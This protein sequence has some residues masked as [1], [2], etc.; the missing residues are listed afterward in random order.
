M[1]HLPVAT[2]PCA[3]CP[4]TWKTSDAIYGPAGQSLLSDNA[5]ILISQRPLVAG[6]YTVRITQPGQPDLSWSFR[7][8]APVRTVRVSAGTVKARYGIGRRFRVFSSLSTGDIMTGTYLA[9][10]GMRVTL[11]KRWGNGHWRRWKRVT[12]PELQDQAVTRFTPRRT[13]ILRLRAKFHGAPGYS[14]SKSE[15]IKLTIHR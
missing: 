11:Q 6:T 12:M 9:L 1:A 15:V 5:V 13:G 10:Y 7:N 4:A 3:W 14:R 2:K 8:T